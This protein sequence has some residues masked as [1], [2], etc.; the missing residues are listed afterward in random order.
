MRKSQLE[1]RQ[2]QAF[3]IRV[4]LLIVRAERAL[5]RYVK[6]SAKIPILWALIKLSEGFNYATADDI[7]LFLYNNGYRSTD[8]AIMMCLGRYRRSGLVSA[9]K[10]EGKYYYH[11][12]ASTVQRFNYLTR[13]HDS[14]V[15]DESRLTHDILEKMLDFEIAKSIKNKIRI[16][17]SKRSM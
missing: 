13:Y 9:E 8:K 15:T 16:A 12:N 3:S 2:T 10:V 1:A 14:K 17:S 6:N 5:V 11:S 7:V 4:I